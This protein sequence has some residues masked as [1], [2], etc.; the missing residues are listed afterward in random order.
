MPEQAQ[1]LDGFTVLADGSLAVTTAL[2]QRYA[3]LSGST[4]TGGADQRTA[5]EKDRARLGYSVFL[6]RL[7]G[8]TQVMSPD[9][10]AARLH[11]RASH[12]HKVALISREIA[13]HIVRRATSGDQSVVETIRQSGGLDISAC[14]TAGLAHDLGHPPFGHAGEEEIDRLMLLRGQA[15]GFEGN[16][17]SFR[18]VTL[19]DVHRSNIFGLDLT[20]VTLAAILKYPWLRNITGAGRTGDEPDNSHHQKFSA[21]RSEEDALRS[22]RDAIF[23]GNDERNYVPT[24]DAAK[25]VQSLESSIMDLA[26]DIAYSI[27]DLEDFLTA[28]VIDVNSAIV[29]L[30]VAERFYNLG[31]EVESNVFVKAEGKLA[32][33][34]SDLFDREEY[35]EALG[36]VRGLLRTYSESAPA[37]NPAELEQTLRNLLSK[38]VR[39]FFKSITV[40]NF[41][42]GRKVR[43]EAPQWHQM[44]VMKLVAK[45]QLVSTSRMGTIQRSQT[46]A[47]FNLFTGLENWILEAESLS[48]LPIQ[49]QVYLGNLEA[50]LPE[51]KPCAIE[52]VKHASAEVGPEKRYTVALVDGAESA[53]VRILNEKHYRAIV[54]YIC[55]MSDS[56]ALV[57]SQWITGTEVPG[58]TSS[59]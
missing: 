43:L 48:S 41:A 24:Q 58:M 1:P 12:T 50:A 19:L 26:D 6:R 42:S 21:Y 3:R 4:H 56:E 17:Q 38:T 57:R 20:N 22:V 2:A 27:H 16:A 14:E 49:L 32:R 8:V 28:G 37:T 46:R 44:Q 15:D 45:R 33:Y 53:T 34:E 30:E 39:S 5:T 31:A 54:D 47:V 11:T 36:H 7:A 9:L 59:I 40:G 52:D 25:P 55:G 10:A 13:E 29:H 51:P 18:I 23:P 35:A